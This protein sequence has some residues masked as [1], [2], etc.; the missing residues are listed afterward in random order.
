MTLLVAGLAAQLNV[1]ATVVGCVPGG[2][3]VV[4]PAE[5]GV[6]MLRPLR[7][8]FAAVFFVFGLQINPAE[9]PGVLLLA[10][11]LAAATAATKVA[12]GWWAVA[13]AGTGRRGRLRA[14]IVLIPRGVARQI[15]AS[16]APRP[17]T[18]HRSRAHD[19]A[20]GH[21]LTREHRPDD[22]DRSGVDK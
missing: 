13:R 10:V 20:V 21:A 12:T 11:V 19:D 22:D 9:I 3:E 14:G 8:L 4:W 5:S 2:R 6:A 1:S 15:T 7:D 18:E 17:E 16:H